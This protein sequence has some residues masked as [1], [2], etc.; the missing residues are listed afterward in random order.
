MIHRPKVI[1]QFK[2]Q[3]DPAKDFDLSKI[4]KVVK[5]IIIGQLFV[6]IPCGII[7]AALSEHGIGASV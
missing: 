7:Y 1:T 6:I 4:G 2:I 3:A 5:N